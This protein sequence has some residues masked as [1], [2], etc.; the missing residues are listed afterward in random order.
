MPDFSGGETGPLAGISR[1]W[2]STGRA[3]GRTAA[4]PQLSDIDGV[5]ARMLDAAAVT[6]AADGWVPDLGD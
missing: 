4:G 6:T 2:P 3:S 1:S 5:I